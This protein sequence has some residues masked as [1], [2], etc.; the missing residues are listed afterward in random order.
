MNQPPPPPPKKEESKPEQKKEKKE[1]KMDIEDPA[2]GFKAEGNAE[3][4][5]KNFEAALGLYDKAI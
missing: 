2:E 5:K 4:K 1:E 3:F